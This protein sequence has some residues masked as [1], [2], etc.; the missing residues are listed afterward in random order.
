[1]YDSTTRDTDRADKTDKRESHVQRREQDSCLISANP[2]QADYH[3]ETSNHRFHTM[4]RPAHTESII[5]AAVIS[6]LTPV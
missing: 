1:M 4:H 2:Q 6:M 5:T 3:P